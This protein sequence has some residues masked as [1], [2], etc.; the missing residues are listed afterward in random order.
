MSELRETIFKTLERNKEAQ[1]AAILAEA[2]NTVDQLYQASATRAEQTSKKHE[3]EQI[4]Q[5]FV[6]FKRQ[7]AQ[8]RKEWYRQ[9]NAKRLTLVNAVL[10]SVYQKIQEVPHHSDYKQLLQTLINENAHYLDTTYRLH[11]RAVDETLLNDLDLP[12]KYEL[13]LDL[14]AIGIR[15]ELPEKGLTIEDTLESRLKQQESQL[16]VAIAAILFERME[17]DPW[18]IPQVMAILMRE[19]M[20]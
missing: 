4:K 17:A 10:K 12:G 18:E 16:A 19:Y 1:I 9:Y 11:G 3:D 15:I 5:L 14:E 13:I 7:L 8:R 20:E 6:D 2:K